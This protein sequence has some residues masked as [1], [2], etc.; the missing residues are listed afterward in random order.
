MIFMKL[1]LI[2]VEG[3]GNLSGIGGWDFGRTGSVHIFWSLLLQCIIT[4]RNRGLDGRVE[5]CFILESGGH[6]GWETAS[7][8]AAQA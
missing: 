7:A 6:S 4:C 5:H 8:L 1:Q 3:N 2:W